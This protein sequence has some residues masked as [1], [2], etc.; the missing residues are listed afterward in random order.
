MWTNDV[1]NILEDY[2]SSNQQRLLIAYINQHT[3]SLQLLHSI[4]S[5]ATSNNITH[6]GL[7]YFIRKNDSSDRITTINEFLKYIRFGYINGKSISCLTAFVSTLFG[8]LF[9]D[10]MTVQDS[11]SSIFDVF[12]FIEFFFLVIKN[13]FASELNQ[14]LATFY[15]IQ[16][17]DILSMTYL[18]VPKDGIDK[19]VEELVKDKELIIRFEGIL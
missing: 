9:M 10:N 18:F 6:G 4:P 15:E 11:M 13:D 8:P 12:R 16:Y 2:L 5:I 3:S 19:T 14:F 17:K 7:C 1:L